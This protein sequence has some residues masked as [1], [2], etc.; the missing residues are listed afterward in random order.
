M[1]RP[2]GTVGCFGRRLPGAADRADYAVVGPDGP[3]PIHVAAAGKGPSDG[4]SGLPIFDT[5]GVARWGDYGAA[6]PD[7]GDIWV[8]NEYIGQRCTFAQGLTN[9]IQSPL[10][11]CG[12]A[13]EAFSNWGTRISKVTP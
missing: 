11:T 4:F 8:A 5:D 13:R 7:G 6:V 1:S 3:G 9:T 12:Y 2:P 10:T